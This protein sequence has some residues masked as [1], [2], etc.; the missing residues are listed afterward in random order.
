MVDT[1]KIQI[2]VD[3]GQLS[4]A[5][6]RAQGLQS[7]LNDNVKSSKDLGSSFASA[8]G[9]VAKFSVA[10]LTAYKL[11]RNY[12]NETAN[13]ANRLS[14]LAA[15]T[16]QNNKAQQLASNALSG[17]AT[18]L[19]RANAGIDGY[20]GKAGRMGATSKSMGSS[21]ARA[22]DHAFTMS[23]A[24]VAV[25]TAAIAAGAIAL[26]GVTVTGVSKAFASF[27]KNIREIKTILSDKKEF[28]EFADESKR[29]AILYGTDLKQ[30]TKAYYDIVSSGFST[31]KQ[32]T[33][34]QEQA[35]KL[36]IAGATELSFSTDLLTSTLNAYSLQAED[37]ERVSD[38]FFASVAAGKTT[39]T[40]LGNAIGTVAPTAASVNIS[41]EEV[42]ASLAVL[43]GQGIKT[44]RAATT[45]S[46]VINSIIKPSEQAR[47]KAEELGIGFGS[48]ALE[49]RGLV[50]VLKQV[51][52]QTGGNVD[53]MAVLLGGSEALKGA[54]TL[55]TQEGQK[56]SDTLNGVKNSTGAAQEAFNE[57]EGSLSKKFDQSL[58]RSKVA[59]VEWGDALEGVSFAALVLYDAIVSLLAF[60]ASAFNALLEAPKE[61]IEVFQRANQRAKD[62]EN[63][64][65]D[66]EETTSDLLEKLE[67]A[68]GFLND[69]ARFSETAEEHT[70]RMN[71]EIKEAN[72][73]FLLAKKGSATFVGPLGKVVD[74][75]EELAKEIERVNE[76]IREQNRLVLLAREGSETFVG[77][78]QKVADAEENLANQAGKA[79]EAFRQQVEDAE[80]AA[81]SK[82]EL[83]EKVGI[84]ADGEY[85]LGEAIVLATAAAEDQ[86]EQFTAMQGSVEGVKDS[87]GSLNDAL[88]DFTD[89]TLTDQ[90]ALIE[91][92]ASGLG[93]LFGLS[94]KDQKVLGG[95]FDI[96]G[97]AS[98]L[99]AGDASGIVDIIA[100]LGDLKQAFAS[101]PTGS[102]GVTLDGGKGANTGQ[103]LSLTSGG[104]VHLFNQAGEKGL[105]NKFAASLFDTDRA[106]TQAL[107][108]IF[109]KGSLAGFGRNALSIASTG[110]EGSG[111]G[112][113]LGATKH[114]GE[115]IR[116][117]S[118]ALDK[119][120]EAFVSDVIP[121]LI[122]ANLI[123]SQE[124][125]RA[126]L[127]DAGD[128]VSLVSLASDRFADIR[129]EKTK[130]A[131]AA[132]VASEQEQEKLE[133]V[134]EEEKNIVKAVNDSG[135]KIQQALGIV[136][137][138]QNSQFIR[139]S[140]RIRPDAA[141]NW[142][143]PGLSD[144]RLRAAIASNAGQW[145]GS[146]S[147]QV[148]GTNYNNAVTREE[149]AQL[150]AVSQRST[151]VLER[152]D[153]DGIKMRTN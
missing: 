39:I 115:T 85:T 29:L 102:V 139:E 117:A 41:L 50:G 59:L 25:K 118:N 21:I 11:L 138:V 148:G 68:P 95:G 121:S 69:Y 136:T 77:P 8:A 15:A 4:E 9:N 93:D 141:G 91:R 128:I 133:K 134:I 150:L 20:I 37:A 58:Q 81:L 76:E 12:G 135:S 123:S 151:D 48:E 26:F 142:R 2:Q 34:V 143:Y 14:K 65:L 7:S 122:N 40:E 147:Y 30:N 5:E 47:E 35:N 53:E 56:L 62:F 18:G 60:P 140:N 64:L 51:Y 19:T 103:A 124:F 97:G 6:R 72:R 55:L 105:E 113:F 52:E 75:E 132:Q 111:V 87:V 109:G 137:E 99:A 90:I 116:S 107:E 92:A 45:L 1:T 61:M 10:G 82:N 89:M 16:G 46:A 67:D 144:L 74:E 27:D 73:L 33:L 71:A 84:A 86:A 22:A 125:Q 31:L 54:I 152:I 130:L 131:E 153:Q 114:E 145:T 49:A 96:A 104:Q 119:F 36:A 94:A 17:V 120:A 13:V 110:V 43:T 88:K 23:K 70:A 108:V 66:L 127:G 42:G 98:K 126:L 83:A 32:A 57:F 28:R 112:D 24:L 38:I 149:W 129:E 44:S 78:L 63:G 100:G 3:S 101:T 80:K 106:L 146:G 79:N